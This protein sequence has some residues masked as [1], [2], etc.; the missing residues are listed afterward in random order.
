MKL[1][2]QNILKKKNQLIAISES[3]KNVASYNVAYNT[4]LPKKLH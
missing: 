1:R 4:L 3:N 2:E